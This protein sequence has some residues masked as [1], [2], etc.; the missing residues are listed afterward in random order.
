[1]AK[2]QGI[3]E[4]FVAARQKACGFDSYPGEVPGDL[5]QAYAIQDAAIALR[6]AAPVGW[7]VGRINPPW[8]E[9]LGVNRLAGPIFAS[10][11]QNGQADSPA[12]G[13]IYRNGFGAA[14]AEFLFRIS[15]TPEA[16]KTSLTLSEAADLIDAVFIGIEVA[17]SPFPGIN[18]LGPLVTISDFGNNNGLIAG[19]EIPDW[20]ESGLEGWTVES[21]IDGQSV[22]EGQANAFTDGPLGSVQF[23]LE[24][25]IA[26][27][28][29]ITPGLLI[30]TGAVS[31]VHEISD[32]QHFEA[33]FGDFGRIECTIKYATA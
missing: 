31:G 32:G 15:R 10:H 22:G 24:N 2:A 1:I 26:R 23:L 28:I 25:L 6:G 7:K 12:T 30:S 16:G 20:R 27:G 9:R 21:F 14:E 5:E 8:L 19:E 11:V 3:A 4:A 18:A 33:R 17:S 29:A 13:Q